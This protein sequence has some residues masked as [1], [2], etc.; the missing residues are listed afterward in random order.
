MANADANRTGWRAVKIGLAGFI[1]PYM[2]I[3]R[4]SILLLG[5][6][7]DIV[8]TLTVAVIG[9]MGL[10]A[11]LFGMPSRNLSPRLMMGVAAIVTLAPG[12]LSD[13]IGVAIMIAG[14]LLARNMNKNVSP[15]EGAVL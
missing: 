6:A 9:L 12:N 11:A 7:F 3:L 2:F 13:I 5:S 4:P 15:S 14:Y 8:Q 10:S 1:L